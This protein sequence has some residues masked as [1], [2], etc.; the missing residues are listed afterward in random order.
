MAA[1]RSRVFRTDVQTFREGCVPKLERVISMRLCAIYSGSSF[2]MSLEIV[3]E[4]L[5][6]QSMAWT[7]FIIKISWVKRNFSVNFHFVKLSRMI[8]IDLLVLDKAQ[9]GVLPSTCDVLSTGVP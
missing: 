5:T 2:M 6:S 1:V 7:S 3:M 4:S 9:L 8:N